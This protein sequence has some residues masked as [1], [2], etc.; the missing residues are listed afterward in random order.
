MTTKLLN[1]RYQVI[2]VLG[3]GGFGETFLAEDTHLPSRRRCVIKQLKPLADE[4]KTYQKIQQKFEREAAT[5]EFLGE[6]SEQIP[7]LF[8]YFS[9]DGLFYLVQEW[10]QGKTLTDIVE[11]QGCLNEQAVR[12]ILLSLLPVLEYVHSKGIIH[13]DIKPDNIIL[14]SSNKK[15]VLIDFGAV[16]ETIRTAINSS[17]NPTQSMVIGTPGYMPIEQAIGRAVF[18]TDIYSLGLTAIYLLTGKHPQEL[19]TN[20]QTGKILWEIYAQEISTSLKTVI[21]KAI[22][23]NIDSRYSTASKMLYALQS[24]TQ[25]NATQPISNTLNTQN[26]QKTVAVSPAVGIPQKHINS[27]SN[28]NSNSSTS[29]NWLKPGLIFGGLLGAGLIG[30]IAIAN[31]NN[32]QPEEEIVI[33]QTP[34]PPIDNDNSVIP[35]PK[36]TLGKIQPTATPEI[37][38]PPQPQIAPPQPQPEQIIQPTPEP[39]PENTQ[40]KPIFTPQPQPQI[41][42]TPTPIPTAT[43]T[44]IASTPPKAEKPENNNP[45]NVS[46]PVFPTGSSESNV[47]ATLGK[48]TK[49]SRGLWNTRAYLYKLQPNQVDLGLLFDRQS[50]KLRQTEASLAQSVGAKAMQNTLQGMLKGNMN[51]DIQ[52]GLQRVYQRQANKY[53][54]QTRNLKG[55]I[56]RNNEGRVYIAVWDADLH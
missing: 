11:N 13:R 18:A 4:P 37:Q 39:I 48:P 2:Q 1:N 23:S 6:G 33:S 46:F 5:L 12:E 45:A 44:P 32:Q 15:P 51:G 36:P 55:T 35:S 41:F 29:P 27:N 47:K 25:T 22:N 28:S 56:Q 24:N 50:G 17:G 42:S 49:V 38:P 30:G 8:A 40:P 53:S 7:N 14:R 54:F 9:E 21:N 43:P 26:T 20:P 16:K 19:E 52:Q 10:I 31:F 34:P 3:A